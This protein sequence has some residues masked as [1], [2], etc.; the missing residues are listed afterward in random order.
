MAA[1]YTPELNK[2]HN[3]K[4]PIQDSLI[5]E[6]SEMQDETARVC[7]GLILEGQLPN[8]NR[9]AHVEFLQ[10]PLQNRL[11]ASFT[12]LDASKP[13]I[14]YW[15]LQGIS[16]LDPLA[17]S[18]A[19]SSRVSASVFACISPTEGGFGGGHGQIAHLASTY[20]A[21]NA[22]AI[23]QDRE[24]WSALDRKKIYGYLLAMKCEDG[25]F[26]M[27]HGGEEDVRAI[28]C[29]LASAALLNIMTEELVAGSAEWISRCQTY[30]GGIG[31]AP[32]NEAHGGYAFCGLA[33]L[34][35]L[36]NPIETVPKYLDLANF[37]QWLSARQYQ[38][39]GGFSGR[40]NK[41]VDGCYS[42]W[43]GG[44][45]AILEGLM[46]ALRMGSDVIWS[47]ADLQKYILCCC[48]SASGGLRDKPGK[49]ADFYHS[50]YVLSG[51]SVVQH[52]Y[53][54]SPQKRESK[55]GEWSLMWDYEAED[56]KV[57]K[58]VAANAVGPLNPVHVL[59]WGV[60]EMM[61]D[62]YAKQ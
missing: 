24:A 56:E 45:W 23:S 54:I 41:L 46:P 8:L 37:I 25:G 7:E 29:A 57:V 1:P 33:A 35:L 58:V 31:G 53:K 44:C 59:P 30:E 9:S 22:L 26:R 34:C 60:A 32:D 52:R 6:T 2:V 38:P 55:L 51:L 39:E 10:V 5:T 18:P 50:C 11:P 61:H 49:S 15:P 42:W 17:L 3:E 12:G 20:A 4:V 62:F 28:Y 47:K 16:L 43:V 19:D 48:Q 13:W 21:L 36:G 40:S 14:M 27:H